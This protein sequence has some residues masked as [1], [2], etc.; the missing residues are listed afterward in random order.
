[1]HNNIF[2]KK[3]EIYCLIFKEHE[4]IMNWI[5]SGATLSEI[6]KK[7]SLNHPEINFS[8]NGFLYNLRNFYYYL[9]DSALKNKNK[10]RLFI[11]KHQ[12]DIAATISSGH[13]LKETQ[14][15]ILPQVTYNCFIVQLRINYP[16]LHALGKMNHAKKLRK[17]INRSSSHS[18]S[19]IFS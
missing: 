18:L 19:N 3:S 1:M 16:D 17:K 15:L 7:L 8:I 14:Q 6:Y 11:I 5:S 9:Y 10:T 2:H 12:D 4:Q 13:T